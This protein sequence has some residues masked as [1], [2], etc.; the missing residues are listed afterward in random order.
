[1]A[2]FLVGLMIPTMPHI[3]LVITY[4][5]HHSIDKN[6]RILKATFSSR[7]KY[8]NN[9]RSTWFRIEDKRQITPGS[10]GKTCLGSHYPGNFSNYIIGIL[11]NMQIII[12]RLKGSGSFFGGIKERWVMRKNIFQKCAHIFRCAVSAALHFRF[13]ESGFIPKISILETKFSGLIIH[14]ANKVI[15]NFFGINIR[16]LKSAERKSYGAHTV[17]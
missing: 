4:R 8:D 1:M 9:D 2:L 10:I 15:D 12:Q 16:S 6:A 3:N 13:I 17:I 7:T 5:F 11:G 14:F